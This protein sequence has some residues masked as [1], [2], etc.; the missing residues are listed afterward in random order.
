MHN[1]VCYQVLC[2]FM[3]TAI[4]QVVT[5]CL[6]QCRSSGPI[7]DVYKNAFCVCL[8]VCVCVQLGELVKQQIL[9]FEGHLA[10][11]TSKQHINEANSLLISQLTRMEPEL[12]LHFENVPSVQI[13]SSL[14]TLWTSNY[15]GQTPVGARLIFSMLLLGVELIFI[16]LPP[17]AGLF[18]SLKNVATR[19][20]LQCL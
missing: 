8:C 12:V 10:A 20:E 17:G 18:W 5:R 1:N 4:N 13:M 14:L 3:T 16:N 2:L 6:W 19:S 11:A 9:E 7:S 15:L